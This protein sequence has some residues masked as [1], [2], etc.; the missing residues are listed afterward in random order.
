MVNEIILDYFKNYYGKF[1][2]DKL[3]AEII[4]KGYSEFEVNEA[5]K[6]IMQSEANSEKK[7]EPIE[8]QIDR[9]KKEI[10]P[11]E[12]EP[13]FKKIPSEPIIKTPK[14]KKKVKP[15]KVKTDKLKKIKTKK[16]EAKVWP[17]ILLLVVLGIIGIIIL[18][19]YGINVLGFNLFRM[20]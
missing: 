6:T 12:E 18:N 5:L 16:K 9:I 11:T 4:S 2:I 1:P 14:K 17:W 10:K 7:E 13:K 15:V 19:Y 8:N 20:I 3:K